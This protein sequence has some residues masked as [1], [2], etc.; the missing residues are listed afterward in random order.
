MVGTN[1]PVLLFS[2]SVIVVYHYHLVKSSSQTNHNHPTVQVQE[3]NDW[4]IFMQSPV[5]QAETM[6]YNDII[7]CRRQA[8]L[9]SLKSSASMVST[10]SSV[11]LK[12]MK[13]MC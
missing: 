12:N 5:H 2:R 6:V 8:T 13:G 10:S 11:I 4:Y 1:V 7:F 3:V 9:V